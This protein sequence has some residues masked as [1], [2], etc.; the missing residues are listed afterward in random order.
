MIAATE[1]GRVSPL[2]DRPL[3]STRGGSGEPM[4]LVH[5][6]GSSRGIWDRIRVPLE[7][8]F[9]VIAIDLPGFGEQPWFSG[10]APERMASLAT[11][12]TEE[13]DR[14]G[15]ERAHL[16][17]HSMG[18][19]IALELA[20]SGRALDV[21]AV[22]PVGGAT[23]AEARASKRVLAR[24]QLLARALAPLAG[25]IARWSPLRRVA[26]RGSVRDPDLVDPGQFEAS[27]RYMGRTDGFPK[28]LGD[29]GGEGDLI[30]NNRAAFSRIGCPVLIAWGTADGVL[31]YGAAARM[32]EAIPGAEL[33]TLEGHGHSPLLDHPELVA[34][35]ALEHAG[36]RP[37]AIRCTP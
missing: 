16:V 8:H 17:G 3:G 2:T 7:R 9:D 33:R 32:A 11:A 12:V 22:A 36:A 25:P 15:I 21:F 20:R 4:L 27:I 6:I 30:E 24:S 28:L 5:G 19:W 35:L 14:L 37:R 31:D 34:E 23:P 1:V 10:P 29:V 26:L 18:G 13:L